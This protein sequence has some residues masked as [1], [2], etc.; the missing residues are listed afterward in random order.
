MNLYILDYTT[1]KNFI[2]MSKLNHL[3]NKFTVY[4]KPALI[5]QQTGLN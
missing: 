1:R 4:T 2:K 5:V 3:N